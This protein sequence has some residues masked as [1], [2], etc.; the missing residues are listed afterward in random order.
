MSRSAHDDGSVD[1]NNNDNDE[2][3]FPYNQI[4]PGAANRHDHAFTW[5]TYRSEELVAYADGRTVIVYHGNRLRQI[6]DGHEHE[7]TCVE[8]CK[9][10]AKVS[11]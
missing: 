6:L 2:L 1:N 8:W 3:V 10:F 5:T 7:V 11:M 4:L 9:P